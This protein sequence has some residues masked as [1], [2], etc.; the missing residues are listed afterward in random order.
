RVGGAGILHLF[1]RKRMSI[2]EIEG[3][4]HIA[5]MRRN[6][7][8][9]ACRW[10]APDEDIAEDLVGVHPRAKRCR[11]VHLGCFANWRT[12]R[13]RS[14][15]RPTRLCGL[16]RRHGGSGHHTKSKSER[17]R[18]AQAHHISIVHGVTVRP[19]RSYRTDQFVRCNESRSKAVGLEKENEAA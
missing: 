11:T 16:R 9:N 8:E 10:I 17:S 4:L 1:F 18:N 3:Q 15:R 19:K 7:D 12:R 5:L 13:S 2:V 14:R 6:R